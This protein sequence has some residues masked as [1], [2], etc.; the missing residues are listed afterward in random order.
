MRREEYDN[1]RKRPQQAIARRSAERILALSLVTYLLLSALWS[2]Y[3][4]RIYLTAWEEL[5]E[6]MHGYYDMTW[7]E[8]KEEVSLL[9]NTCESRDGE[10]EGVF[11]R[12]DGWHAK[13]ASPV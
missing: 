4:W 9:Q 3:Y 13:V 10:E 6:C 5:W 7:N 1:D 12:L 8:A 2:I 11:C